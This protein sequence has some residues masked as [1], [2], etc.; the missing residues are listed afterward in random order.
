MEEFKNQITLINILVSC[1]CSIFYISRKYCNRN[2]KS[3]YT[4]DII[5]HINSLG[6][7]E[8][9]IQQIIQEIQKILPVKVDE[10]ELQ[11]I[12]EEKKI[13]DIKIEI[14]KEI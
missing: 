2:K 12:N 9:T 8:F 6:I 7:G 4:N 5:N 13:D 3:K 14:T 11:K 10:E 1:F